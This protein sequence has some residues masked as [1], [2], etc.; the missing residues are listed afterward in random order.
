MI[1][2]DGVTSFQENGPDD[3]TEDEED[4]TREVT[5]EGKYTFVAGFKKGLYNNK[6]LHSYKGFR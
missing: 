2:L 3:N 4:G 5:N 6:V 1:I